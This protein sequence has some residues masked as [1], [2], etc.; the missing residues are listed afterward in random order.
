MSKIIELRDKRAKAWEAAKAFLDSKRG[1]NELLTARITSYNVCYTKL[2]RKGVN[3]QL[4]VKSRLL[5]L[6]MLKRYSQA[7][8]RYSE[9]LTEKHPQDFVSDLSCRH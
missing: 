5:L 2:L 6:A 3:L 7:L 8:A 4:P 1:A 9:Q